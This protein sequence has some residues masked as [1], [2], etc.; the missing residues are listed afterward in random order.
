MITLSG[1]TVLIIEPDKSI[2]ELLTLILEEHDANVMGFLEGSTD[3]LERIKKIK[4][5][6]A[7]IAFRGNG[8]DAI[9]ILS[10][11]RRIDSFPALA[12]SCDFDIDKK[13][14]A[15]GFDG[16]I[17][18]PFDIDELYLKLI[19]SIKARL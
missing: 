11:L 14:K 18:K 9:S 10:A 5:D 2:L 1:C 8:Q 6:L 4:I 19:S 17:P 15:S 3:A 12:F 16:Y 13:A 7:I